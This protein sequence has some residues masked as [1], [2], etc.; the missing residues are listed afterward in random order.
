MARHLVGAALGTGEDERAGHGR[1]GEQLDQQ[2]AL[3]L[4]LDEDDLLLDAVRGLGDGRHRDLHG[5]TQQLGGECADFVRHGGGEEHGLAA[6][7]QLGDDLAQRADE[8][9]VHHLIG[10]VEHQDFGRAEVGGALGHVID[11]TAGRGDEDVDAALKRHWSAACSR[12]RRR[13]WRR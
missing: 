3:L 5:I 7:R 6:R 12:R 11:E 13:W 4:S 1:I 8:A 2:R 10:F 9:Q